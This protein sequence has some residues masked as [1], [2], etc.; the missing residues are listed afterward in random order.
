MKNPDL[1]IVILCAGNGT[2]MHSNKPKVLHTLAGKTLIERV[3]ETAA[4][5]E[6]QKII[7]VHNPEHRPQLE[8]LL[9]QH[10]ITWVAQTERRGT[11]HAVL[12]ALPHLI[13]K[14]SL[15]LY[16]DVP[17][18]PQTLL[19]TLQVKSKEHFGMIT[20]HTK[21]PFGFGRIIRNNHQDIIRIVEEKDADEATKLIEEI[22]TGI[23]LFPTS[24]LEESLP[25]LEPKN[26]QGEYYLTDCVAL[27][28]EKATPVKSV[29]AP[30]FWHIQG[31]NTQA[32]LVHLERT[33]MLHRAEQLLLKGVRI[34]D[35]TRF[36]YYGHLEHQKDLSIAPNVSL[37]GHCTIGENTSIGSECVLKNVHIGNNVT[38]S[39]HCRLENVTVEDGTYIH[40]HSVII[41]SHIGP[42]AH[43]GPFAYIRPGTTLGPST[44]I[45]SF[46]ETKNTQVAEN[47]KVPHLA[48][49]GDTKIEAEVNIG[50][51]FV[52]ANYH[53]PGQPKA[54][55]TIKE[56]TQVGAN[57]TIV[58]PCEVGA[59]S[60]IGAGTTIRNDIE[61]N[62]LFVTL[63]KPVEKKSWKAEKK[64]IS[65]IQ[66]SQEK[67]KSPQ[68]TFS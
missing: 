66:T 6:P 28:Q 58:G 38:L 46:V 64:H 7:L 62:S 48:Y 57:C 3:V 16:G 21:T 40:S 52:H 17:L 39:D 47:A 44:K 65:P 24:F 4:S 27:W 63:G 14:Q 5:L 33:W 68:S 43:V 11:G 50:A 36:D 60:T 1:S 32:E 22:N 26:A 30:C 55:S 54:Y 9:T 20:A 34:A 42:N 12:Q 37:E 29:S 18:L 8:P 15:V 59:R 13:T 2:R 23:M 56:Q 35:P 41:Q 53:G 25:K 31:V 61:E 45:G 51:G 67:E 49:V 10:N 19:E